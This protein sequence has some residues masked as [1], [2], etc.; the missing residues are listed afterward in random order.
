MTIAWEVA[1][2]TDTGK[3]RSANEDS[4]RI[5]ADAGLSPR[6]RWSGGHASGD[7]ASQLAADTTMDVLTGSQPR[8]GVE[9]WLKAAFD[10]SR[11]AIVQCC[12]DDDFTR[13]WVRL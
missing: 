7:V 10:A 4:F 1:G 6:C 13:G 3:V 11:E 9:E 5:D 2:G 12:G 8:D